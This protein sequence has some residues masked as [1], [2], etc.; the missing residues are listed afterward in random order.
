MNLWIDTETRSTV[1]IKHGTFKYFSGATVLM[2]Q[3]AIEEDDVCVW[4]RTRDP[5]PPRGL[6]AALN[7][8]KKPG[9]Q[10]TSH[11]DEFDRGALALCPELP[12]PPIE[13]WR[14]SQAYA[15]MASLPGGLDK[16]CAILRL[17][18]ALAKHA[19]KEHIKLFCVP[20]LKSDPPRFNDRH[21]HPR[22]WAEFVQYAGQD[23]VAMRECVR[24]IPKWNQTPFETKLRTLDAV[25]NA[26]GFGIDL[27]MALGM[28]KT[29][30]RAKAR[31]KSIT[32]A[33]TDGE[34][35]STTQRNRLKMFLEQYG[36][37]LPDLT[38][39]TIERRLADP[40]LPELV[41]ELLRMRLQA[42]KSSTTK[43]QRVIACHVNGSLYGTLLY[44]GARPGRWA[45]KIFQ[46]HNLM[47]PKHKQTEIDAFIEA[48]KHDDGELLTDEPMAVA[49]SA[50]RGVIIARPGRKLCV[51]DLSN[52]EGRGLPW[53]AGEQWKL[54]AFRD[55]DAGTGSDMYK[56]AYARLFNLAD[57]EE[58]GDESEER[59]QGKVVELACGY[60]GGVGAFVNMAAIYRTDLAKMA[61]KAWPTLPASVR[62]QAREKWI[63][64][65]EKKRTYDL[66][67][68]EFIVCQSLV[69]MWRSAHPATV[70]FWHAVQ[71]AA[72]NAIMRP[73]RLFEAGPLKFDRRGN[74]LRMHLPSGR[75]ILY[76]G[77]RFD[78]FGISYQGV[79]PYNH[80]FCR[81]RTYSG[82]LVQNA[83][84]G[85]SRDQ[86]AEKLPGIDDAGSNPLLTVHDSV[87]CEPP[88]DPAY[89]HE[90]LIE[91]LATNCSWNA[92][93]PLAAKGYTAYRFRK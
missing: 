5:V 20:I 81:L 18:P 74:W 3:W 62:I 56:V 87:I 65:V 33:L 77:P 24:L 35:E 59:Q 31:L 70:K 78:E 29:C 8:A 12:Q 84:E 2:V 10:I 39:D 91:M 79:N 82:R 38:A 80:Q 15:R 92:G 22:E 66:C 19:G 27:P 48:V 86:L 4:D 85:I 34:V 93:L 88:D 60:Y 9:N 14:C 55:Y 6:I 47:R 90:R 42:S 58:V 73:D 51:A 57:P 13:N 61:E 23:I 28:V 83:D 54:D 21:S 36:V 46:P 44:Y 49:A 7:E 11:G 25:M 41:K 53:M 64:A 16:L 43:Y 17:P 32:T 68:K 63:R 37:P 67:E 76:P 45:G 1:A 26:R 69:L 30:T 50:M 89:S 40:E 71:A 75:F 52:I 72:E